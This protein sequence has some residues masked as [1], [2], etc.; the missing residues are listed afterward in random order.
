MTMN[1]LNAQISDQAYKPKKSRVDFGDYK[2]L[3]DASTK[4]LATY[5]NDQNKTII[6]GVKGTDR[7]KDL[8]SDLKLILGPIENDK[9]FTKAHRKIARLLDNYGQNYSKVYLTGH[10]LGGSIVLWIGEKIKNV[11][12][13]AYNPG[14]T[15]QFLNKI[16]LNKS[17]IHIIYKSGDP[18]SN[19]IGLAKIP[20]AHVTK[21]KS[22]TLNPKTEHSIVNLIEAL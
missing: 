3:K 17:N 1:K 9:I 6:I 2:Y 7:M 19:K 20:K 4:I 11:L 21:I 16:N 10:S 12:I 8:V 15:L 5:L 13:Y 14:V 22:E 18:I